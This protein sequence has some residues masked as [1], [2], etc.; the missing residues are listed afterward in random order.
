MHAVLGDREGGLFVCLYKSSPAFVFGLEGETLYRLDKWD[1]ENINWGKERILNLDF[2]G[3][4]IEMRLKDSEGQL[5][6]TRLACRFK[7]KAGHFWEGM[8]GMGMGEGFEKW[9]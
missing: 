5:D 9:Y 1:R 8:V 6:E 3:V 7:D 2:D 4:K